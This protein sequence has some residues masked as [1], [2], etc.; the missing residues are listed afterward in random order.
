[1]R[2]GRFGKIGLLVI[3][4]LIA[5]LPGSFASPSLIHSIDSSL[6]RDIADLYI[7]SGLALPSTATPYS[8]AQAL[9]LLSRIERNLLDSVGKQIY[10]TLFAQ[11][12][13][14]RSAFSASIES[15]IELYIHPNTTGF[16]EKE[17]WVYSFRHRKPVLS[18]PIEISLPPFSGHMDLSLVQGPY[19][20]VEDNLP[21]SSE[22]YGIR[23]ITTNLPYQWGSDTTYIDSNVP[24]RAYLAVGNKH[25]FAQVGK[26][27]LSWG[28]GNTGNF[29]IGDHVQYHNFAR[30]TAYSNTFSYTF[31]S[32]F[33]PHPDE[34]YA[35]SDSNQGRPIDGLKMFMGYRLEWRLFSDKLQISLNE[36]I[37]Y[38]HA[39][40]I[41]D[42]RVFNPLSIYH[43]S[44]IRSNANSLATLELDYAIARGWNIYAQIA[45]DELEFGATEKNLTKNRH[46]DGR[47]LQLG[48]RMSRPFRKGILS[49][50]IEGV[51]TDP[52]L[53]HRSIHGDKDQDGN[54]DSLNFIVPI[55]RWISDIVFYDHEFLGYQHGGD[56]ISLGISIGYRVPSS[57]QIRLTSL[58]LAQGEINKFSEWK[59]DDLARAPSGQV[60]LSSRIEIAFSMPLGPCSVHSSLAYLIKKE[61]SVLEQDVQLVVGIAYRIL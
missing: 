16:T 26:D 2:R 7:Q 6:Y 3:V 36:S 8:N 46:P 44:Y 53:Y 33:F 18:L 50:Y 28:P 34:V 5:V 43:N 14:Q 31:L 10:D 61:N 37:M 41:L 45:V 52:Y 1:M 59:L 49:G 12:E 48:L 15:N 13:S 42:L 20:K 32:S 25:W 54:A 60:A 19:D 57:Y 23:T 24:N 30:I 38:Q 27:R 17:D 29:L 21:K 47:A 58:F 35:K 56:A 11:M 22:L 40:G 39:D 51:Y 4:L 9:F 55:R